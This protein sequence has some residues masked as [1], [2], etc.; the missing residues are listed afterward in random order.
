[1]ITHPERRGRGFG[2][3]A[4][5]H[6]AAHAVSRRLLPQ[7]RT[8]AANHAAL[9]LAAALGFQPYAETVAVRFQE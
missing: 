9:G 8:L 1:M 5:A 7:Y 3:E 6:M 2:R 4:V